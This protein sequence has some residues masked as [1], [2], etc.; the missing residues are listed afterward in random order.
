MS[1]IALLY[2]TLHALAFY[3]ALF[4]FTRTRKP[5]WLGFAWAAAAAVPALGLFLT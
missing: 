1:E 2:V 4:V 3:R 5:L